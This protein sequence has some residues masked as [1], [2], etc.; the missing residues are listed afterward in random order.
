MSA[1]LACGVNVMGK[2][3]GG[4]IVKLVLGTVGLAI[5]VIGWL[6]SALMWLW[7]LSDI[8]LLLSML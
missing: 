4:I 3:L 6:F 7:M 8:A 2:L 1:V 5:P